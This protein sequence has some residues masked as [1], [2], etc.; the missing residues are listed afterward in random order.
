MNRKVGGVSPY[1]VSDG[2]NGLLVG[3]QWYFCEWCGDDDGHTLVIWKIQPLKTKKDSKQ[4][5]SE[6]HGGTPDSEHRKFKWV[7]KIWEHYYPENKPWRWK[8]DTAI[9]IVPILS[10]KDLPLLA[11]HHNKKI[12]TAA[13]KRLEAPTESVHPR[14]KEK[15]HA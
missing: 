14:R 7:E 8:S 5:C 9:Y 1:L 3:T 10:E 4:R 11:V 12:Q 13:L 2:G 15:P 6:I